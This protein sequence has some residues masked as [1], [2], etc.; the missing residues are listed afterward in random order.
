[1]AY[2]VLTNGDKDHILWDSETEKAVMTG[3]HDEVYTWKH[4]IEDGQ[5]QKDNRQYMNELRKKYELLLITGGHSQEEATSFL[6]KSMPFL[7]K[8]QP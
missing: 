2:S 6:K 3:S 4:R 1:M 5:Q 7:F 8:T